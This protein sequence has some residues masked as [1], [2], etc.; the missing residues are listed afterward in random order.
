M[1]REQGFQARANSTRNR[2]FFQQKGN[3]NDISGVSAFKLY[4]DV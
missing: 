1:H 3:I 4:N 2:R